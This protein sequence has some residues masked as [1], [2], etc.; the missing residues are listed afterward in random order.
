PMWGDVLVALLVGTADTGFV[1]HW[2]RQHLASAHRPRYWLKL[3]QLPRNAMGKIER[4]ALHT[5]ARS[6]KAA[7]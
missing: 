2:S 6:A 1:A 4:N 3:E 5:L 7:A